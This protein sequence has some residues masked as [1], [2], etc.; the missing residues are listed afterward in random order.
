M[1]VDRHDGGLADRDVVLAALV[2]TE[3]APAARGRA[4]GIELAR[5]EANLDLVAGGERFLAKVPGDQYP[6]LRGKEGD[7]VR[8]SWKEEDVQLLAD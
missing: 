4:V 8:I 5:A 2:A 3:G 7:T 1:V 6:S